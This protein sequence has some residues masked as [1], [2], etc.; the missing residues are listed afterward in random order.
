MR[1]RVRGP[2]A[3]HER[4]RSARPFG[5][6]ALGAL[7]NSLGLVASGLEYTAVAGGGGVDLCHYAVSTDHFNSL[8]RFLGP[9]G[10][11]QGSS[12]PTLGLPRH[13]LGSRG[14]ATLHQTHYPHLACPPALY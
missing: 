13:R 1:E 8:G 3:G 4:A 7:P 6:R 14:R 12:S 9:L 2:L 10:I 11:L 5:T